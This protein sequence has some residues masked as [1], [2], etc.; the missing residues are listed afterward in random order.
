MSH[1]QKKAQFHNWHNDLLSFFSL[2]EINQLTSVLL[3]VYIDSSF[4]DDQSDRR[5]MF[6]FL[7]KLKELP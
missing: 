1:P 3:E 5:Q 2:E 4:A 6:H 7:Q